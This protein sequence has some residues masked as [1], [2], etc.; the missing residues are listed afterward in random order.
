MFP[1]SR[2]WPYPLTLS[3]Q[4]EPSTNPESTDGD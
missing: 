4:G 1:G 2:R 3:R